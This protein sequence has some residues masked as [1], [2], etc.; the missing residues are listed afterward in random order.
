MFYRE[1]LGVVMLAVLAQMAPAQQASSGS[2]EDV[3]RDQMAAFQSDDWERAFGHA[4]PS[5]QGIFRTPETFGEMVRRG[6]PMVWRPGEI[7]FGA[8]SEKSDRRVQVV[9]VTDERGVPHALEYEMVPAPEGWKIN[10]VR[11]LQSDV[12]A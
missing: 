7:R 9:I 10:G 1:A 5:I 2:V 8:M 4:S 11:L 12:G 3:I 6:Y